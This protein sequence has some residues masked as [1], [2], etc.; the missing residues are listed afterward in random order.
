MAANSRRRAIIIAVVAVVCVV[1]LLHRHQMTDFEQSVNYP[2]SQKKM[3]FTWPD[4]NPIP[5]TTALQKMSIEEIS[6][7]YFKYVNTLQV[8]CPRKKVYGGVRSGWYTCDVIRKG[9]SCVAYLIAQ[10][11][12]K[13]FFEELKQDYGCEENVIRK[14]V[15]DAAKNTPTT[16]GYSQFTNL[17]LKGDIDYMA[18]D[19]GGGET[20]LLSW[21]LKQDLLR[22]VDQLLV[23][24]HGISADSNE[25]VYIE[26]MQVLQALYKGGF[27]TFHFAR[28][29]QCLFKQ[30]WRKT[31][32]YSLYMIRNLP[33]NNPIEVYDRE[34]INTKPLK[35]L[36]TLYN[37]LLLSSQIH[38]KEVIRIGKVDDGGW[39]VCNDLE[40]RPSSPCLVYSFGVA[41]DWSFD[42]EVARI[43]GCE[44][45]SFD[46]SIGK[47]DHRRSD[48]ITFHNLGLWGKPKGKKGKW[49]MMNM[50]EIIEMLGHTEKII[51]IMKMDIEWSEWE[52]IPDMLASGVLKNVRQLDFEFHGGPNF[53]EELRSR[54]ISLRGINEQ[55]FRLFW[56]HPNIMGGNPTKSSLT[57]RELSACNENYYLNINLRK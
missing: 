13:N 3:F 45:H 46:P 37:S 29:V 51:D 16:E 2:L 7:L 11:I 34:T 27:R 35:D 26:H 8:F 38:C 25:T 5:E 19:I 21:M 30:S 32:C 49:N 4:E 23:S 50:K 36:T 47:N 48:K 20:Q 31:G 57:G 43:Y 9:T 28:N 41:G 6:N 33:I 56:S 18:I 52:A 17:Q 10:Y 54:L 14:S 40:Y 44:V 24:F 53:K 22:N 42:D 15:L 1:V 55:G 12:T 39:D